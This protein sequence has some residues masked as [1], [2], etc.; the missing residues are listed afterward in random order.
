MPADRQLPDPAGPA[1]ARHTHPPRPGHAFGRLTDA[2]LVSERERML[3][4]LSVPEL[5][6]ASL[7]NVTKPLDTMV[8][9]SARRL[10]RAPDDVAVRNAVGAMFGALLLMVLDWAR[11]PDTDLATLL[12]R[13]FEEFEPGLSLL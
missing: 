13:A 12:D 8:E 3:L 5:W 9:L 4:I 1:L 2:E 11:S 7:G 6:A 10:D